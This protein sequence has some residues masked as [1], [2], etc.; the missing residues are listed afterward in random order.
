MFP[1]EGVQLCWSGYDALAIHGRDPTTARH[2]DFCLLRLR[3]GPVH[4]S[5]GD[6]AAQ[7]SPR[8]AISM[9]GLVRT[10]DRHSTAR[11]RAPGLKPSAPLGLQVAGLQE[12][13]TTPGDDSLAISACG[14]CR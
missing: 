10:P 3:P 9:P 14:F 6:L 7:G 1:K 13:A 5:L 4:P 12:R 8:A 2:G 11:R